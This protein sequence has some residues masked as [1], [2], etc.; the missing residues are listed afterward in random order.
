[1]DDT[2]IE[3]HDGEA[4]PPPSVT[5][6]TFGYG[7]AAAPEAEIVADLRRRFR[8]P[9][10]DPAMRHRTGLDADVYAHV[11][12]TAGVEPFA[13]GVADTAR[14]LTLSTGGPI[15][16]GTGC[17]GGKHRAVGMGRRVAELLREQGVSV[18]LEHRDVHREVLPSGVHTAAET[19]N[20]SRNSTG[21]TAA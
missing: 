4:N 1:M 18:V 9:H 11:L 8:N 6:I 15:V 21:T 10:H 16:V 17:V 12:G 14:A 3:R 2:T 20:R 5:V 7:H 13:R 19:V